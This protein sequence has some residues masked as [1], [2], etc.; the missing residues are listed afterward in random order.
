MSEH[1]LP[2]I[3]PVYTGIALQSNVDITLRDKVN[4]IIEVVN[5]LSAHINKVSREATRLLEERK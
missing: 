3:Q 4:E 1:E 2:I 5:N